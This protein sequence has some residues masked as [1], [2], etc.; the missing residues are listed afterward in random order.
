MGAMELEIMLHM[1]CKTI[2]WYNTE[3]LTSHWNVF[4]CF[5][6]ELLGECV[7]TKKIQVAS[8]YSMVY[9]KSVLRNY[10]ISCYSQYSCQH[11]KW[12]IRAAHDEKVG[13]STIWQAK[14]GFPVF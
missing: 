12:D 10:F 3:H 2:L 9:H 8:G 6:Q 5:I 4:C 1:L 7:Y 13:C 14:N 11:D